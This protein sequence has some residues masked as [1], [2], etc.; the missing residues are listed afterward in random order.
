MIDLPITP[1]IADVERVAAAAI[2][3]RYKALFLDSVVGARS[4]ELLPS[5]ED[6]RARIAS[7]ARSTPSPVCGVR[8]APPGIHRPPDRFGEVDMINDRNAYRTALAERIGERADAGSAGALS[9]GM[10]ALGAPR[11]PGVATP[12]ATRLPRQISRRDKAR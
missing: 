4:K 7:I 3:R 2:R 8:H 9:R 5:D 6:V 12:S 10:R 1:K 11:P